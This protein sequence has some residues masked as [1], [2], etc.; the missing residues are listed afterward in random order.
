MEKKFNLDGI[1]FDMWFKSLWFKAINK[2]LMIFA[3]RT[4]MK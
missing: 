1:E 3:F 4:A 2:I